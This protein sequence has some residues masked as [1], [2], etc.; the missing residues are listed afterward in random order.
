MCEGA[1]NT[2]TGVAQSFAS[3]WQTRTLQIWE[4]GT[5]QMVSMPH[6]HFDWTR[7]GE[8]GSESASLGELGGWMRVYWLHAIWHAP[9][10][11]CS[12]GNQ[13]CINNPLYVR[14]LL[15]NPS[16]WIKFCF[17]WFA[18]FDWKGYI[19]RDVCD[20]ARTHAVFA[21]WRVHAIQ[22]RGDRTMIDSDSN[23]PGCAHV[24]SHF[25]KSYANKVFA[26]HLREW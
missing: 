1:D 16:V 26:D 24:Q 10:D 23:F 14:I 22:L 15:C 4:L 18:R 17:A 11:G 13:H 19:T 25:F 21:I 12:Y 6:A 3:L 7:C 5:M 2:L 9:H 8:W 20:G